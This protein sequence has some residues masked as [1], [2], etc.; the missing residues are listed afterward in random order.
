MPHGPCL[1]RR[2]ALLGAGATLG[3]AA[4]GGSGVPTVD[5]AGPGDPI[6]AL[7][8]VP[9]VGALELEV[10]GRRVLVV[11]AADDTVVAWDAECPHQGCTVRA[12]EG[13]GL[14]CP[15]HGSEFDA[16]SGE[17]LE[18]PATTGLTALPV[19]VS[20]ADVVLT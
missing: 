14:G 1:S 11:R 19:S 18:G 4:C 10:D 20:G 9:A 2:A 6:A 16:T 15:C 17:V 13:G 7:A 12:L 8:D 3:L 5:G